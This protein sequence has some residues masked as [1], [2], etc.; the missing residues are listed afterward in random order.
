[1]TRKQT[2][3]DLVWMQV[4]HMEQDEEF[5]VKHIR[6]LIDIDHPDRAVSNNTIRAV[7]QT[8]VDADLLRHTGGG[9]WFVRNF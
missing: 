3:R 9:K 8:M 4:L 7:L 5:Q 1:M 2:R 6:E